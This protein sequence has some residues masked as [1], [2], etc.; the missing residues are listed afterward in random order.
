M[1]ERGFSLI[2][3]IL[4][5]LLFGV[6]STTAFAGN[7]M[8]ESTRFECKVC[9]VMHELEYAKSAAIATGMEY[10]VISF[11]RYIY[12]TYSGRQ[13]KKIDLGS[14]MRVDDDITG[15]IIKFR[16]SIAPKKAGTIVIINKNLGKRA[17]ITVGVGTGMIRVYDEAC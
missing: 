9:E 14:T 7:R 6:I 10:V 17:R 4:V 3:C 15:H 2:E 1:D 5:L 8:V 16:D 12:V 13:V 11:D